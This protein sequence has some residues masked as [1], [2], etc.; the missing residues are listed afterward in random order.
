M[1]GV[2]VGLLI[3]LWAS[4]AWAQCT[5][6]KWVST[7]DV[8][9]YSAAK[10]WDPPVVPN[11]TG[12]TCFNVVIG[13]NSTTIR[14]DLAAAAVT[15]FALGANRTF[16]VL[17]HGSYTVEGQATL[18]GILWANAGDF[19]APQ[20]VF[21]EKTSLRRAQVWADGG[22]QVRIGAP[23]YSAVD[24]KASSNLLS[25]KG[26]MNATKP[27]R[28]D[29]SALAVLD[30][31][32]SAQNGSYVHTILAQDG[33]VIDLAGLVEIKGP[34]GESILNVTAD[35]G[36]IDLRSLAT[37][38]GRVAFRTDHGGKL[39]LGDFRAKAP[40]MIT[41][42]H[43]N[44]L[45]VNGRDLDL[46]G[47]IRIA[48]DGNAPME[49]SGDFTYAHQHN[50]ET[51]VKLGESSISFL[52]VGPQEL[53]VGG[54]DIG[55]TTAPAERRVIQKLLRGNFGFGRLVV[56]RPNQ[57][58]VVVLVDQID[59]GNR[60][61]FAGR[62]YAEALYL[63]GQVDPNDPKRQRALDGLYIERGSTLYLGGLSAYAMLDGKLT[64]LA[65]LF[66]PKQAVIRGFPN[67]GGDLYLGL[68][69][70]N[71]CRNL[72][73]NGGF[74]NGVQ[75]PAATSPLR[76][77]AA[78]AAELAAWEVAQNS[79]NWT[80][81]AQFTDAGAGQ[82]FA[83]LSSTLAGK[84]VLRQTIHTKPGA[85]YH[86][87][88]DV[89]PHPQCPKEG[90]SVT[91]R[92]VGSGAS[93]ERF[94]VI[95]A[96]LVG[97]TPVMGSPRRVRWLT[98]TWRFTAQGETTTLEFAAGDDPS[99]AFSVALDN[100]VVLSPA[101]DYPTDCFTLQKN[102]SLVQ[103][104][105][106]DPADKLTNDTTPEL[107]LPFTK[108]VWAGADGI[109]IEGPA[110]VVLKSV[111]GWMS[112]TLRVT[113]PVPL[114][115][116][117][118]YTVTLQR[119]ILDTLGESLNGGADDTVLSFTLDTT[120]PAVG[121]GSLL[122][123]DATP[124]LAGEVQEVGVPVEVVVA[125][126]IYAAQ[127]NQDG[128]WT[129][130]DNV[131]QPL[132]DGAY[133]VDVM[134]TDRAGNV[135]HGSGLLT[136]DTTPPV[137]RVD[138]LVTVDPTPQL[139]GKVDDPDAR[140]EVTVGGTAYPARNNRDGTWTLPDDAIAPPLPSGTHE[141]K[142]VATDVPGNVGQGSGSLSL[143]AT[144]PVAGVNALLTRD[145]TPALAGTVDD[146][147]ATVAVTVAGKT[148][149]AQNRGDG[150]WTL[151]DNAITPPLADGVHEVTIAATDAVGNVGRF[152]SR[153]LTIDTTAPIVVSFYLSTTDPSPELTG[154][155]NDPQATVQVTIAGKTY[156]ARNRGDGTWLLPGNTIQP[157]LELGTYVVRVTATDLAGNQ[158][159]SKPCE[160]EYVNP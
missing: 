124:S 70:V 76:P 81:E 46:G 136:I 53:E 134:A 156:T 6:S 107:L 38:S 23:R 59:N 102:W 125:G 52:G 65:T 132:A 84:G 126:R 109:V 15:S 135:G 29:L 154:Q 71:D 130:S 88:F 57:P 42:A 39:H 40:I 155:V 123:R 87:W 82:R 80:H 121:A 89:A 3:V 9:R 18:E 49:L 21:S 48:N 11:N 37:V 32:L 95:P 28:L 114:L 131:L 16:Q 127:N 7:N 83:D 51:D 157:A 66:A 45:L 31:S 117:G 4:G 85:L 17:P 13:A 8:D 69:D 20:A 86:V 93:P 158:G 116:D 147:N 105:G 67:G 22:A 62:D 140:V 64:D 63:L 160:L 141:V 99:T 36:T 44:D 1:H 143:D 151:P 94:D 60:Y 77:I 73:R 150:T 137:V 92:V 26:Q 90:G 74:E 153:S 118:R 129:L 100:V 50:G 103:D 2:S 79:V 10:S 159:V 35:R 30:D 97:P 34:E 98:K 108:P 68:P 91:V 106:I 61:D 115:V 43:A 111:S 122:T 146:P 47:T 101:T 119:T 139:T 133:P 41:L 110:G 33:G 5:T 55:T 149:A 148:Y 112:D 75:P 58:T 152:A 128:T 54:L 72:I 78:G 104:T 145:T 12:G 24:L 113:F 138:S 142:V 144:A 14:M 19:T 25:A 96:G 27:S 56:G 120:P